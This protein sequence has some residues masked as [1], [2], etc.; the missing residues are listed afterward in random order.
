MVRE[1]GSAEIGAAVAFIDSLPVECAR[2]YVD[3][4]DGHGVW[5]SVYGDDRRHVAA[6]LAD[7]TRGRRFRVRGTQRVR[8]M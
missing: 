4:K 2:V 5:A 3:V 8:R 6:K 7:L 1:F